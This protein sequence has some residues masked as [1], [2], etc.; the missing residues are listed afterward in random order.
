MGDNPSRPVPGDNNLEEV[1]IEDSR[2]D[3]KE[4]HHYIQKQDLEELGIIPGLIFRPI[5]GHPR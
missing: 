2:V 3:G 4:G 5:G 1:E